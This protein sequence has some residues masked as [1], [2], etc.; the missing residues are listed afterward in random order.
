M[1]D[2]NC[3][4]RIKIPVIRFVYSVAPNC[5]INMINIIE[6][7]GAIYIKKYDDTDNIGVL[8]LINTLGKGL[9]NLTDDSQQN[10]FLASYISHF[11]F[12]D[13]EIDMFLVDIPNEKK[14]KI[15]G[16]VDKFKELGRQEYERVMKEQKQTDIMFVDSADE[17]IS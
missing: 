17:K 1:I 9:I 2:Y 13:K 11:N 15:M 6:N 7:T 3:L 12:S 4:Y 14:E 8:V 5:V 16:L 10:D